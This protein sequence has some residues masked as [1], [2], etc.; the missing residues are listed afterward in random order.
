[1]AIPHPLSHLSLNETNQARDIVLGLHPG[2]VLNFRT[3]YLHEPPK[4]EVL[5]F[6][7]LEHAGK[8]TESTPRPSR[9]AQ[10]RYDVIKPGSKRPEYHESVV[11][12]RTRQRVSHQVVGTEHHASL[13]M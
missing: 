1:M 6:L 5:P 13:T 3:V 4:A 12:I 11:D 8:V 10:A 7:D 9:L 2:T